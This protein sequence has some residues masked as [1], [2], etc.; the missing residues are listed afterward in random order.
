MKLVFWQGIISI[1]QKSF[2]EAVAAQAGVERVLLVVEQ[3]ITHYRKSM[4]WD[5]PEVN[6]VTVVKSPSTP[7]VNKLVSDNKDAIHIMGGLRVGAMLAAAFDACALLGCRIGIMTE[8]YNDA[9]V[10]G[11]LRTLKYQYY[12]QRYF[13]HI[14][15]VLGI[16]RQSARQYASLGFNEQRIFPWGYFISVPKGTRNNWPHSPQRII[17]AGRLEAPKGISRFV[18]QLVNNGNSNYTL[19]IYGEGADKHKMEELVEAN[20]LT[21]KIR[22]YPFLKHEEL[23]KQYANYD[24]VVLPSAAKDGWGVIVSEGLLNGL[25]AICSKICGVSRVIENG[26]N[27]VVFDWNEEGG[28]NKAIKTMLEDW[29][30]ADADAI[31]KWADEGISAEAGAAYFMAVMQNVYG[32]AQKPV[33]PW[34][35]AQLQK[36]NR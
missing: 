30:F 15:F 8:P 9:G 36:T 10:K 22:F 34:E 19:D 11:R 18:E 32:S 3:E 24:W 6:G 13:K 1:H 35:A 14:Q 27:G 17:Y 12:A 16:G 33:A 20:K 31:A 2:L 28:C 26:V 25:K 5:V 23:V 7:E 29:H 21:D 4:G